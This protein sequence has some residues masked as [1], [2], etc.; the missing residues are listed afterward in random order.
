MTKEQIKK[1][2]LL[3]IINNIQYDLEKYKE[4]LK[5]LEEIEDDFELRNPFKD[6][7][8]WDEYITDGTDNSPIGND[9]FILLNNKKLYAQ[10]KLQYIADKLNDGWKPDW[11]DMN[12]GKYTLV[13]DY[14][15][16]E[17]FVFRYISHNHFSVYFKSEELAEK[18]I[19]IMGE[20]INYLKD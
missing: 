15:V 11:N 7:I 1:E 9:L 6:F 5:E 3:A 20:D 12:E 19:E 14:D 16:K 17:F 13:Y 2:R 10:L 18:A 8:G 4:G